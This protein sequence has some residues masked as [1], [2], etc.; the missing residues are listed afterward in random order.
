MCNCC[1]TINRVSSITASTTELVLNFNPAL[2]AVNEQKFTFVVCTAIPATTTPVPV[3]LTLNGNPVPLWNRYGNP[4]YS[5]ELR[6]RKVY[7]GYY[8]G[9]GTPHVIAANVPNCCCCG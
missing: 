9:E 7:R 3:Q 8:G 6:T 1:E 5:N 4:I 2:G